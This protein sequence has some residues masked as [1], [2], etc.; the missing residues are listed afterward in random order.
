MVLRVASAAVFWLGASAAL[1][2]P[3][4]DPDI[5]RQEADAIIAYGNA[6]D[7]FDNITDSGAPAI[8]HRAS[9][10]ICRFSMDDSDHGVRLAHDPRRR[11]DTVTCQAHT[12][13]GWNVSVAATG[14][15]FNPTL[16]D[17]Y[18]SAGRGFRAQHRGAKPAMGAFPA[19]APAPLPTRVLRLEQAGDGRAVFARR[20]AAV[21]GRWVL[22][23]DVEGPAAEASRIDKAAQDLA[24]AAL[25]DAPRMADAAPAKARPPGG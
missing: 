19:D 1:A 13:E 4:A 24:A 14:F 2:Q 21:A 22:L 18:A 17:A 5:A 6:A 20:E 11:T 10:L 7:A 25:K 9:G 8:R 23:V 12:R 16:D 3:A 15:P